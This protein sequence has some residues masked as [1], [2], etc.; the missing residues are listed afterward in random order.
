MNLIS[1]QDWGA[2]Q[3]YDQWTDPLITKD[4]IAVHYGGGPVYKYMDGPQREMRQLRAWER[5]HI[6]VR[7]WR[8]IAYGYAIGFSGTIYRLRGKNLYGAHLGD[9]DDDGIPNNH[10]IIPVLFIMGAGQHTSPEQRESF[11]QL[12]RYLLDQPW[13]AATLPVRGHREIQPKPTQCPGDILM[14]EIVDRYGE[15][16]ML[17][18]GDNGLAV[19]R[20]QQLLLL[21]EPT[22]L[23]NFGADGDYGG[24]TEAAVKAFQT[25]HGLPATGQAGGVTVA[26]LHFYDRTPGP[27]GP[28]GRQGPP[29]EVPS[30]ENY[31]LVPKSVVD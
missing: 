30:L 13:T 10:E 25:Q 2:T 5:Y 21:N 27:E 11:W 22:S 3:D 7:G 17:Q 4:Q 14:Q 23:P 28:P 6:Q 29:G 31:R 9:D 16:E 12:Y 24:E 26:I 20:V 15:E 18:R 19:Q 8:G 1:P